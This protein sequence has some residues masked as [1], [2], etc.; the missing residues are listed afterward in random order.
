MKF[1]ITQI[2][3]A[4]LLE[5]IA[6]CL[7]ASFRFIN[8]EST[9]ALLIFNLLFFSLIFQL[10]GSFTKKLSMLTLGNII[11]LAWNFLLQLFAAAGVM[12]FGEIFNLFYAV[13][14]PIFNFM[15]I[16][17]FWSVSLSS[18]MPNNLREMVKA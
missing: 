10:D 3:A 6:L 5:T 16:I 1:G 17:S 13:L 4:L 9:V 12:F 2:V 11:G 8:I 7:I 14:Q 18:F 15:W